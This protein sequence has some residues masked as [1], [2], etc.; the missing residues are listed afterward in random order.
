MLSYFITPII[1]L[2]QLITINGFIKYD[3]DITDF[4][5]LPENIDLNITW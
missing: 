1:I 3:V 2:F 5:T 4:T